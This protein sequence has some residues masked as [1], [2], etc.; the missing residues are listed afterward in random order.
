MDKPFQTYD[1]VTDASTCAPRLAALRAELARRGT[2]RIYRAALRRASGRIL[3]PNRAE[4]LAWLT[5]FTG[6]AGCSDG[7]DATRRRSSSMA[8]TRFRCASRP[9]PACSSHAIWWRKGRRAGFET[10]FPEGR[11]AGLRPV[12][13]H[14]SMAVEAAE[15]RGRKSRR[16]LVACESNPID[17]VWSDQPAPPLERAAKPHA[18]EPRRAKQ[19]ESKR[20]RLAEDLKK[21]RRRSGSHHHGRIRSAGC[22]TSVAAT[23]RTRLSRWPLRFCTQDGGADLSWMPENRRPELMKHLGNAVRVRAA[24]RIRAGAGCDEGQKVLA[25]P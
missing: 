9:I 14:R 23:C 5:A 7:A 2:G 8:A 10:H 1:D 22:S 6:S 21:A 11:K 12:A 25:D 15:S 20:M 3:S 16:Q 18:H 4:R 19:R 13:A 17:A 24:K